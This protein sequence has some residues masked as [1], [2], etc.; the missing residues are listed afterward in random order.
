MTLSAD[1][2][3]GREVLVSKPEAPRSAQNL[4]AHEAP[5][6]SIP[7][8][9]EDIEYIKVAPRDIACEQDLIQAIAETNYWLNFAP[10]LPEGD[11]SISDY[12]ASEDYGS[13]FHE[14]E[15]H[16][17]FSYISNADSGMIFRA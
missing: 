14:A 16:L 8:G 12:Q 5:L 7:E 15:N 4:H 3:D 10:E 13:L 1:H 11:P 2:A 17:D 9:D 6:D